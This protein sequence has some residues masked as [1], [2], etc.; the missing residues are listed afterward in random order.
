KEKSSNANVTARNAKR[1]LSAIGDIE[2]KKMEIG[3]SDDKTK[4]FQ[5]AKMKLSIVL[6]DML[7]RIAEQMPSIF[8]EAHIL[9]YNINKT[10]YIRSIGDS[11]S[12]IDVDAPR[13]YVTRIRRV[14]DLPFP[15]DSEDYAQRMT[16]LLE[17]AAHGK[18]IVEDTL[19]RYR[20]TRIPLTISTGKV[21]Q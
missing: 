7:L 12:L 6:K 18:A 4:E 11:I 21:Q 3:A 16:P 5:D 1:K 17:L 15:T 19:Y 13:G 14:R 9:G 8:R 10:Y 2:D 20:H